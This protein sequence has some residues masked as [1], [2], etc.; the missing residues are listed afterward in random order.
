MKKVVNINEAQ[1]KSILV[2]AM[3]ESAVV[4]KQGKYSE[5]ELER[6]AEGVISSIKE[7]NI[8]EG[9]LKNLG[10]SALIDGGITAY[11]EGDL[12]TID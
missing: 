6:I 10:R 12:F 7:S 3:S 11:K 8:D 1:L 2:K 9:F 5:K 4:E